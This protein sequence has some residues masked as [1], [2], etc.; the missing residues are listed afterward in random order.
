MSQFLTNFFSTTQKHHSIL[1]EKQRIVNISIPCTHGSFIN[2]N[3][4]R[5]PYFKN[6]HTC[7]WTVWVL[8]S[9]WVYNIICTNNQNE[10][11]VWEIFINFLHFQHDIIWNSYLSKK[12][13]HLTWHT[14]S[15][16][17]D[18]KSYTD[19]VLFESLGH[20]SDCILSLSHCHTISRY[21]NYIFTIN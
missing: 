19:T 13:I 8:N 21:D 9:R 4:F 6:W 20:F 2:D 14:T 1:F 16:R 7:N 3:V 11:S 10:I 15:D 12:Y 17:V 5:F 18:G